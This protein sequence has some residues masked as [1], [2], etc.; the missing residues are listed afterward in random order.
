MFKSK[1]VYLKSRPG[2]RYA[3]A[4]TKMSQ[5]NRIIQRFGR[6]NLKDYVTSFIKSKKFSYENKKL[7]LE[8]EAEYTSLIKQTQN[9]KLDKSKFYG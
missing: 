3:S 8:E 7:L 5:N 9:S 4:L 6:I 2:E 1:I